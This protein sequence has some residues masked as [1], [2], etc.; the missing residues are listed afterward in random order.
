MVDGGSMPG[1]E[2]ARTP[3]KTK[4]SKPVVGALMTESKPG[5]G[6]RLGL[7]RKCRNLFITKYLLWITYS[8]FL[9]SLHVTTEG[10]RSYGAH[11]RSTNR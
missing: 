8:D 3:S 1:H 5:R 6:D 2:V 4:F 9:K 11:T 7:D 10:H